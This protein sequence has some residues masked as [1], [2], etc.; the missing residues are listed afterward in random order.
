MTSGND[1]QYDSSTDITEIGDIT[2]K[3]QEVSE[4]IDKIA[5][6]LADSEKIFPFVLN[7]EIKES[8]EY[9]RF[10]SDFMASLYNAFNEITVIYG[11]LVL[12]E[13]NIHY[14]GKGVGNV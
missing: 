14:T 12:M 1:K 2:I 8:T 9:K 10:A 13:K 3:K 7:D 6:L 5:A 4:N 11:M